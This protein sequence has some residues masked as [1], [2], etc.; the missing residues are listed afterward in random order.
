MNIEEVGKQIVDAA[1]K[2]HRALGLGSLESSYQTCLTYELRKRGLVVECEVS[3]PLTYE[4]IHIDA[5]YLLDMLN[6]RK[7]LSKIKL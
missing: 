6:E 1:I 2:V 4:G 5:G 7:A 3:Q